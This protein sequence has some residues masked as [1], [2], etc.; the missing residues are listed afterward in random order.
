[1]RA[2][3]EGA[4]RLGDIPGQGENRWQLEVGKT[5]SG[6]WIQSTF[7][8]PHQQLLRKEVQKSE[9]QGKDQAW[10]FFGSSQGDC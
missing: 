4:R 7:L 5:F 8:H 3:L 1:M 6:G 9:V 10:A 2:T